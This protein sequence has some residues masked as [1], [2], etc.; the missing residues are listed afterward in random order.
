MLLYW[1][2]FTTGFIVGAILSFMMFAAK[3]PEEDPDYRNQT[4]PRGDLNAKTQGA[5]LNTEGAIMANPL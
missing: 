3:T 5:S 2:M 4:I 1:G